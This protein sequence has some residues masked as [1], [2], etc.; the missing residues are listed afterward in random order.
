MENYLKD[1]EEIWYKKPSNVI[2]V[3]VNPINGSPIVDNNSKKR[4]LY[5]LK[6]TEPN[7]E[8][9]VFDELYEE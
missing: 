4:I 2:G 6:G 3:L 8:E 1:K 7:G 5:Y 9:M